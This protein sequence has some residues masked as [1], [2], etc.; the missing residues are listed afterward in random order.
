MCIFMENRDARTL[1]QDAQEEMR[2]QAVRALKKGKTQMQVVEDFGIKQSTVSVWWS[3]FQQGGWSALRKKKR[4]R[5]TGS[6]RKM[7]PEQEK[8]IQKVLTDKTPDQLKMRFALWT[9]EAVRQLILERF[10]IEYGLQTMSTVLARWDFT[11]QRPFKKAYEQRPAEVK[12]WMEE[13][14][15]TVENKA[16]AE[17]AEI[18]W[19]DETAIKPEC[20]F[21]RSYSPKGVTPVVRQSA[22]RFHSSLISA[23]NNQGKMQWMPLKEAINSDTFLKFLKQLVKFRKRKIILIVDNLRVHHSRPVKDWLEK[24]RDR[25]EL[26]FLPAYSPE[27]NPDEYWNNYL[28]QTVTAEERHTEKNELDVTVSLKMFLFSIR[29][30]VVKSFFSHPSVQ[31][32]KLSA[33]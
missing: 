14:Y 28:K 1:S 23:V 13:T 3:S 24:N 9:R 26:V 31:Y 5:R 18:W 30:H 15:P 29:K 12:Q 16:R 33:N 2:R 17:G 8:E 10:G 21:R 20:H 27:L 7:S 6:G 4:G 25:I 32:A 11:P 22:K 19:G